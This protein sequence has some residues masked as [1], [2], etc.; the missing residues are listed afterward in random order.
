MPYGP[1]SSG[2]AAPCWQA[3]SP[4]CGREFD[5]R[6]AR[7][8]SGPSW[9]SAA[10]KAT[11]RHLL[12]LL[13]LVGTP[14]SE[15]LRGTGRVPTRL[16]FC[17][18]ARPRPLPP[19]AALCSPYGA[20]LPWLAGQSVPCR[21]GPIVAPRRTGRW[22]PS[23]RDAPPQVRFAGCEVCVRVVHALNS[24]FSTSTAFLSGRKALGDL[25]PP[26]YR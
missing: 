20:A 1:A 7:H 13:G 3:P 18:V 21:R 22:P 17:R 4:S 15:D 2:A 25:L 9:R 11:C 14:G 8:P 6:R 16:F 24:Y 26:L 23:C 5:R 12:R 10:Q 19:R